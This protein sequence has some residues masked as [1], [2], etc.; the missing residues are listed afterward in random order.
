MFSH[1]TAMLYGFVAVAGQGTWFCPVFTALMGTSVV[2][3]SKAREE[4]R[5]KL[6]VTKLM[7]GFEWLALTKTIQTCLMWPPSKWTVPY[8][9]SLLYALWKYHETGRVGIPGRVAYMG[10]HL[11]TTAGSLSLL[12]NRPEKLLE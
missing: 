4:Y 2:V 3:Q 8:V 5:G 10:I 9:C 6:V 7:Y 11:V 1:Y 12:M